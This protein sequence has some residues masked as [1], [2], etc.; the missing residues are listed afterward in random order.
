MD[1]SSATEPPSSLFSVHISTPSGSC[2]QS[3]APRDSHQN[4][5]GA[6]DN[7]VLGIRDFIATVNALETLK[8]LSLD[9]NVDLLWSSILGHRASLRSLSVRTLPNSNP[10]RRLTILPTQLGPLLN[11]SLLQLEIDVSESAATWVSIK[12][13]DILNL[14]TY[15]PIRMFRASKQMMSTTK[16]HQ[17]T[18]S[19]H[20]S[21]NS[22]P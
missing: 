21:H 11:S 20:N 6:A 8:I 7:Y 12:I 3:Q 16:P 10:G 13:V 22:K 19:C 5:P 1:P 2:A 9:G 4:S 14:L 17:S 18:R 15:T